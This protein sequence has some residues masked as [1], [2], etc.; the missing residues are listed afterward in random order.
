[1]RKFKV[2]H[3]WLVVISPLCSFTSATQDEVKTDH[4]Y[5]VYNFCRY[6]NQYLIFRDNVVL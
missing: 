5:G 6:I 4:Q 1:M 3:L 2:I